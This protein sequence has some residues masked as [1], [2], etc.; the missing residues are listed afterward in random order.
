MAKCDE[1]YRCQVCGGDVERIRDSDLYLRYVIGELDPEQL[2]TT[3]E[4][5]LLCNPVL[6]QFI[7]DP[8]FPAVHVEGPLSKDALD[9]QFVA[10]RQDLVTRGWRRLCELERGTEGL[11]MLD[12]PL[13]EVIERWKEA[14]DE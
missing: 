12:Y 11:S 5:H 9:G 7:D 8:E 2:H 10:A 1:G 14:R 6:A 3:G 4:R 13:P